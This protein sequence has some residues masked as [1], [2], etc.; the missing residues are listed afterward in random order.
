MYEIQTIQY[1]HRHSQDRRLKFCIK[2]EGGLYYYKKK[3][4]CQCTVQYIGQACQGNEIEEVI[5]PSVG[6]DRREQDLRHLPDTQRTCVEPA[7]W[8]VNVSCI[9]TDAT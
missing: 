2:E 6:L 8:W 7:L 1:S 3:E 5:Q 4:C 9:T